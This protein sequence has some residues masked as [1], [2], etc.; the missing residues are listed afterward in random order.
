MPSNNTSSSSSSSAGSSLRQPPPMQQLIILA[1]TQQ[2]YWFLGHVFAILFFLLSTITGFWN[3]RSSL[4]YYRFSLA[5]IIVTYIIVIK[6]LHFRKS[7]VI[8]TRLLRDENVQYLIL[9]ISFFI[10]SFKLGI[11]GGSLY[12]FAIFALFHVLNYFQNHLLPIVLPH[13]LVAQQRVNSI[14]NGFTQTYNQPALIAASN[15][16]IMLLFL[17]AFN[18]IPTVLYTLLIKWDIVSTFLR[19][20]VFGIVLAFNKFRYD[21]NQYTKAVIDQFDARAIELL[22]TRF[23]AYLPQY[24]QL[25]Q[26]VIGKYISRIQLPKEPARNN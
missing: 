4:T 5:S 10:A 2:F 7:V 13:S 3:P 22:S 23:P 17:S 21:A 16:E 14:I 25:K 8:S 18:L 6:Q 1:K 19:F 20:A 15:A 9:A 26:I 12:S 11:I 24:K